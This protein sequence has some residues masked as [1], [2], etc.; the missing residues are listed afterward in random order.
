MKK[1]IWK[2]LS[3]S[4]N[5]K[6]FTKK[7]PENLA[8]YQPKLTHIRLEASSKCQLKCSLCIT[9]LRLTR[10]KD[11]AVGWGNLSLETFKT[12][13]KQNPTLRSIEISN[14]GEIFLNPELPDIIQ[15][16]FQKRVRLS[17]MNGVNLNHL[18]KGMAEILVKY[19]FYKL[20]ASIDGTSQETYQIYREGGNLEN[21]LA[22]IQ[23]INHFK[24]KY[25]SKYPKLKWQF[26]IFGH[27][28]HQILEARLMAQD[29][30]MGFKAK[31]NYSP[32]E[33]PIKNPEKIKQD[34]AQEVSSVEEYEEKNQTLYSPACLQ[35]WTAPQVNW[36]GKLLGCCVNHFG[37]FGNV[38]EHGLQ[39][40]LQ[41][42]KYQYAKAMV[43]GEKPARE[44]IPCT[45]C[46]RYQ[47]VKK[48]PFREALLRTLREK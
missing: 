47:K 44:D 30:N 27:N 1:T 33:F 26:I 45:H 48:M 42:E 16:A 23:E 28:E 15:Y 29:L 35:L 39:N 6:V 8:Q 19:K 10:Q 43:L 18:P 40:S 4:L 7:L 2:K 31:F 25:N 32:K 36:N 20:K 3:S 22:N 12:I 38:L 21:V 14:Y 24:E 11:N 41:S 17:A 46:K 5:S 37:D 13:L 9:G 34:I